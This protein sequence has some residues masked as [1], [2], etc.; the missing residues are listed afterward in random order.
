MVGGSGSELKLTVPHGLQ[1]ASNPV[2]ALH[3]DRATYRTASMD[4]PSKISVARD[5]GE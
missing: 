3:H 4:F 1:L 5:Y 2:L